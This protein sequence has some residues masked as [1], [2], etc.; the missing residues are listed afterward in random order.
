MKKILSIAGIALVTIS[1]GLVGLAGWFLYPHK[2][3]LTLPSALISSTSTEG[4]ALLK[5]ASAVSDYPSLMAS[6]Q[7]QGLISYCG[8][9]SSVA[10]L[11][12]LELETTQYDFFN[13]KASD[14]RPQLRVMFGGMSLVDLAGLLNAHQLHVG[15]N[16]MDNISLDEFRAAVERNLSNEDDYLIVNYQREVLDQ[17][18]VGHISPLSAY[19][20]TTDS[21]LIM[22]TAAHKYPHTWV[23]IT[24]LYAGMKTIDSS[25]GKMRGYVEVSKL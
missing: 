16:H 22:D 25:S 5:G 1:I 18:R 4:M 17:G 14:V 19:N 6:F 10:V 12:A 11:N 2:T 15:I 21:V 3:P 20:R 24:L 13:A 9:A 7:P 23:P 8:V